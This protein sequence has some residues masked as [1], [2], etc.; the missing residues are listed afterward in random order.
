L[1][2]KNLELKVEAEAGSRK[3]QDER[4]ILAMKS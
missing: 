3:A 4:L 1:L 2:N